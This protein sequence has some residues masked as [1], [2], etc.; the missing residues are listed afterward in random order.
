MYSYRKITRDMYAVGGNDRRLAL[1]EN[2]YPI[3]RGVSYNSYFVNDEK[4]VLLDTVDRAVADAFF[5]NIDALLDGR[6]LD[7]VIVNHMEPDHCASLGELLRRHPSAQV[8]GNAKTIAMV[9]QFF[10]MDITPRAV[11]VT[12]GASLCTGRHTFNFYMAPMVHWPEVM[13]TYDTAEHILYSA[14]AFG[15]FGAISGN[16]YDDEV[17]LT[18][19]LP[20]LRRYY[21]NIVGKYGVQVQS[22][23]KK[24]AGL[25]ISMICP[26]HGLIWR[27]NIP[28]IVEKYDR[29]SSYTPE[30]NTV[31][32]AY[33]SV[34]GN[35]AAAAELLAGLLAERGVRNIAVYDVS[36]THP[37]VIV[38]E[39]FRC[40]TLVFAS[41]TYNAEI[42]TN[43][44]TLLMDLKEHALCRRKVALIE[45]GSWGPVSGKK[46]RELFGSMKDITLLGDT[47]T[48][49]SALRREQIPALT[50]LA[51][52]ITAALTSI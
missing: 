2:M 6:Q 35:T 30:E 46:M 49:K 38:S 44:Q 16:L 43:M 19:W 47:L 26:L 24:A 27:K 51:D 45:N 15:T 42:F 25:E 31:M 20:E 29:W 50:A 18:E 11:I 17:E 7:Y 14:D 22:L 52:E 4:T 10:A 5:E 37:S 21:A 8:V 1:F 23:L 41:S 40:G 39:A 32:I 48:L 34:Y 9:G 13:V 36:V 12:E 3:P 28:W 33:G